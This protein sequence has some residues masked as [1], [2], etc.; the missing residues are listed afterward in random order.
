MGKVLSCGSSRWKILLV[1]KDQ[2]IIV[3]PGTAP[4]GTSTKDWKKLD[5]K[6]KSTIWLCLSDSILLNVSGEATTKELWDKLGTL[7][8]SKSLVNKLFL[9]KKLYNLR[10]KDGDSVT[11]H[12]NAF[13]TMV[14]QLLSVDIN[15]SDE[16]KCISLLCSLPDSWDSLVVAIGSNTTTLSF[17]DVVS[18]LLSEEMRQKE[19]G[20]TEHRCIICKRMLPRKK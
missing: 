10:M 1:D 3:D 7:Y 18:S 13:N 12:L 15:I 16:D 2:W 6:V 17:D 11:E 14:S 5:Q 8:Q 19:H 4:T 9:W 20:R